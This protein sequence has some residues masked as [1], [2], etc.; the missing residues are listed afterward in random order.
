MTEPSPRADDR[1]D[2]LRPILGTW[3]VAVTTY[4]TDSTAHDAMGQ[5]EITYMNRGYAYQ[6]RR[7][8]EDAAPGRTDYAH[9]FLVFSPG[10]ERWA[11]GEGRSETEHIEV[12]DG[13]LDGDT[14]TLRTA[15]RRTGGT[16]LTWERVRYLQGNTGFIVL[17]ETSTDDGRTWAAREMRTYTRRPDAPALAVRDDDGVP[18]NGLPE[19][20]RQFDFLLG[21]WDA[22]HQLTLPTGPV[23]FPTTATASIAL[24]GHGVLEHSWF[25]LDPSLP[26]AATSILRLYNRAERRWESLYLTNRGNT[27]LDFGGAKEGDRIVLHLFDTRLGDT[28]SRFVF[29]NIEPDGY[30]WFAESSTDRGAT[31]ATTWT[32]DMT[33]R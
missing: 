26:D 21:V 17:V 27:L 1:L 24:G 5:A 16:L 9:S 14:L 12:Y 19:E 23:A 10:P 8:V 28:I 29:H 33:R 11:L 31:F 3:D 22:Q 15:V 18:A 2:A 32:I 7:V 13:A 25:D 30:R 4:P 6:E 20:A